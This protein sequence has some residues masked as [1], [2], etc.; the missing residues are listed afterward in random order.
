MSFPLYYI[1]F[2]TALFAL[3]FLIFVLIDI[4][5]LA[6]FTEIHFASFFM[7]FIFLAGVVYILFWSWTLMQTINWQ[8]IITIFQNISFNS[9]TTF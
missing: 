7:T 1:F 5:H 3:I 4:Y 9:P 6:H 2:P 8:E